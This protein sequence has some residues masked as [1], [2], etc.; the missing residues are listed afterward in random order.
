M[1]GLPVKILVDIGSSDSFIHHRLVNLLHLPHQAINPFIVTLADGTDITS[2]AICPKVVWLI[3]DYQF[4]FDLKVM[5]LEGWDIILG[6][7]WIC[8]F[9]PITFDFHSRSI[10]LSSRGEL[11]HLEGFINQPAMELVRGK[12]LRS[13]I[14]EK[15]RN[16]ATLHAELKRDQEFTNGIII[17]NTS[18]FASPVLLVIKKDNSWRLCIDYRKLNELTVKDRFP[19]P[20]IDELLDELHGTKYMSKLDLR[21]GYH[22][23]RVK[24][25]DTHKTAFQTHHGHLNSWVSMDSAKIECIRTWPTPSTVKELR[26]FLGL[27]GYYMRFI[28]GYGVI[29]KPLTQLLKKKCFIWNHNVQIAFEDLKKAMTTSPVLTM[30][31]FEL[32]FVIETDACGELYVLV[33]AVTKWK[34]YLVGHHFVIRTDH[35]ALKYLLEQRLTHLLQQKWPTKLLGLDYEIQYKK[36]SNNGVAD[37][38]SRR[39]IEEVRDSNAITHYM[40]ALSTVQPAWI[41]QVTPFEA[42]YG[43][44]SNHIPVGPF[45]DSVIPAVANMV[46]DRLQVISLIK[47]N[48]AKAQNRMNYF[49]DKHRTERTLQVGDWVFLKLQPYRQQTVAIR[50][51]LKLT[52]MYFGP[53]QVIA[54]VEAMAYKLLLLEG[55][56][57]YPVFHVSLLK[58]KIGNTQPIEPSLPALDTADQCLLKPEKVLKRRATMQN[59][60]PIVQYLVKWNHLLESESSWEDK[61]FI[62]KQFPDF[63][64]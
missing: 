9:N 13:F 42:L 18:P 53:F 4:Q 52:A 2:G 19:I 30:P 22:Q 61:N 49:A 51:S 38:L 36:G 40:C 45:H 24:T 27:T 1:R 35:Q 41:L 3:Q 64:A 28:K 60:Q 63:Q 10:A 5:E 15:Q 34:H 32:L 26:G 57:I 48:L 29:C 59:S 55:A 14:Q 33:L 44:K 23:L 46:Q 50:K 25:V 31:D 8:Q 37:A 20:N 12:D 17:H 54:K 6:I 16:C 62:D 58:K 7:G 43:Y 56:R 39:K 11:L 47:E 21:A